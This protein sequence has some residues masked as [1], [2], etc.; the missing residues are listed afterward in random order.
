V[1]DL[2][3]R[4]DGIAWSDIRVIDGDARDVPRYLDAL[5]AGDEAAAVAAVPELS[6]LLCYE[7]ELVNEATVEAMPFLFAAVGTTHSTAQ[8]PTM[9]LVS[10]IAFASCGLPDPYRGPR[11]LPGGAA[12]LPAVQLARGSSTGVGGSLRSL[13]YDALAELLRIAVTRADPADGLSLSRTAATIAESLA[14]TSERGRNRA[15]AAL[16]GALQLA[17]GMARLP[18]V[19]SLVRLGAAGSMPEPTHRF[20]RWL[21]LTAA[22]DRAVALEQVVLETGFDDCAAFDRARLGTTFFVGL[23]GPLLEVAPHVQPAVAARYV[24]QLAAGASG[25]GGPVSG[26]GYGPLILAFPGRSVPESPTDY[27]VDLVELFYTHIFGD[28]VTRGHHLKALRGVGLPTTDPALRE[29]LVAR[30]RTPR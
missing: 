28:G 18:I 26:L 6:H 30:G 2:R 20:G 12:L 4:L 15:T 1:S 17:Q 29:W 19:A 9:E 25:D 22:A 23:S 10:D 14:G 24:A 13:L 11:R 7:D 8:I 5:T 16:S 27:Q 21:W 3:T